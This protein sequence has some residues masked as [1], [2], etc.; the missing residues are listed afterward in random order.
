MNPSKYSP[1]MVMPRRVV[2][3]G[4]AGGGTLYNA[5]S[6]KRAGHEGPEGE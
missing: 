4:Q 5:L 3:D 1:M 2:G 6:R